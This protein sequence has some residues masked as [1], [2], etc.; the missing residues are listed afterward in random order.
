MYLPFD[1]FSDSIASLKQNSICLVKIF[2]GRLSLVFCQTFL[3]TKNINTNIIPTSTT[4][5][6]LPRQQHVCPALLPRWDAEQRVWSVIDAWSSYLVLNCFKAFLVISKQSYDLT[7]R[8]QTILNEGFYQ[9]T[10]HIQDMKK[11]YCWRCERKFY[12]K[13]SILKWY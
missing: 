1:A 9:N 2:A 3:I 8:Y 10:F 6:L 13:F 4:G 5:P 7:N 11:I 12:L